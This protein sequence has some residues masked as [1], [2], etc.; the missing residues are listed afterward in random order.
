M[1]TGKLYTNNI[2]KSKIKRPDFIAR[3]II[4]II[5][6]ISILK[7]LPAYLSYEYENIT[8]ENTNLCTFIL[9]ALTYN[10]AIYYY[11]IPM[12]IV[13]ISDLIYEQYLTRNIY[14]LYSTRKRYFFENIKLT[15]LFSIF[16]ILQY[17]VFIIVVSAVNK[18]NMT[19]D[20]TPKAITIWCREH[21]EMLHE[22]TLCLPKS[23]LNYSPFLAIILI[24]IKLCMGLILIAM[25]GYIFSLRRE[26]SDA[27]AL[28]MFMVIL[29]NIA[30]MEYYGPWT[31]Y[32]I[33]LKVD[34]SRIFKYITLQRFFMYDRESMGCDFL[35]LFLESIGLFAVW[36]SVLTGI[37]A[38]IVKHK[39]M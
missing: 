39:D 15:F 18:I 27:G 34:L 10:Y 14:L 2:I 25:I 22:G 6:L 16:Y 12:Y 33:G 35:N 7:D 24:L 1:I 8:G 31:F 20:Y 29:F 17:F 9:T 3:N 5:I 11:F 32:G 19:F 30:T 28:A 37:S 36:F 26:N 21:M 38:Y 23:I 13:F 4:C